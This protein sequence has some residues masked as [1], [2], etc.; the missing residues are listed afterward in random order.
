MISTRLS[1]QALA[2][3]LAAFVFTGAASA[4]TYPNRPVR[5]VSPWPAG[6]L[7]DGMVRPVLE[8][9]SIAL[10]KPV[11]LESRS[12][13]NGMVGTVY[14][15][16]VTPD[17][18]TILLSHVG[19]MAI[20]PNMKGFQGYDPVR[21]F[22][23]IT[24]LTSSAM[25]MIVRNDLPVRTVK[26]LVD[27]GKSRSGKLNMGSVGI[28]STTHLA[29]E[30]LKMASGLDYAHIPYK[31]NGPVVTDM[32]GGQIDY[33]FLGYN[34]VEPFIKAGKVRAIAMTS[35]GRSRLV[36][37]LPSINESIPGVVVDTWFA[38]HAPAGTPKEIV[39]RLARE[40]AAILRTPEM[41]DKFR[42]MAFDA[43]GNTPDQL[44]TKLRDDLV[45]W[46]KV[47]KATGMTIN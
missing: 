38:M 6:G 19:P 26:E 36:P 42:Q 22:L 20:S 23:P 28:G 17:G 47:V 43:V 35:D 30:M 16:N 39:D 34:G 3:A 2:A 41:S 5:V 4:Q 45:R 7:A 31:G 27:Y 15:K 21:D 1:L 29:A 33:S 44:S 14:V 40:V 18:Y 13:A 10:G 37:E 25:V 8:K 12:G 9:L 11:V 46:G 24:Q 32:L